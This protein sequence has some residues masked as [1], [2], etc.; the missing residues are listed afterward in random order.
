MKAIL[1]AA[2]CLLGAAV[3]AQGAEGP[4]APA[5]SEPAAA[6]EDRPLSE[7]EEAAL[8]AGLEAALDASFAAAKERFGAD[9]GRWFVARGVL[10]DR[11][12]RTV[13]LDA[14]TTGVRP[15]AIVEFLL[16]TLN[17]GH[18]YES[19]F[20]TS[21]LA[22]DIARAFDF[23]GLPPGRPVDYSAFRFWPSGELVSADVS[24]DGAGAVPAES[25]LMDAATKK[26]RTPEGFL[27]I[28][29]ERT[30]GGASNKVD[31]A[32]PGSIVPSYNEPISLFDVPR[33]AQQA[34]VYESCL[35]GENAS[36]RAFRP[37]VLAFRPEE[38]PAGAPRRVRPVALRLSPEGF[39]VDG[40]DP[41]QPAEA[42][43]L[44]R[45]FR[46]DRAQDAFV[47]FSWDDASALA[48][49][50]A[51]AQLLLMV[52]KEETGIR[53]DAPPA[54]FP[55]YQAFLPR[56]EWRDRAARYSQPC[57]LRIARGEDG[58]AAATLVAIGEIWKDDAL[59]PDLDVKEIPVASPEEFRAKLAEKA[60]DGISALLVFVPGAL[61]YGELRPYL[62]AVR[63]T[64]PLVQIFVD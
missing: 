8:K 25:L 42:L 56:D 52:D 11:E 1:P 41:V 34:T 19:L 22:A 53:V 39:S 7:E 60:P 14:W 31:Y 55:Y 62:D 4:A 32:G 59:K 2:L 17:S 36:F 51:V 26:P 43:K 29:G 27:W 10:A 58:A 16:I 6:E 38:R 57:E 45:A 13:R 64:H 24:V 40:A 47:S 21:A 54:G 30:A 61:P 18:D 35:A 63:A 46:S 49:L 9:T 23:L 3:F 50:R 20:Q 28:G 44:L 12:S 5:P 15:G 33:R 37:A 48:D